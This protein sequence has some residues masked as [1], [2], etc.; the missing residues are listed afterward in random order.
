MAHMKTLTINGETFMVVS[1]TPVASVKVLA[2]AWVGNSSPYS[3]VVAL[4]GV[5]TSTKVDIQLSD[6]QLAVFHNKDLAFTT[7]NKN[8][9][10]TVYAIGQKPVNDYTFQVSTTEVVNHVGGE[11]FGNTVGTP[12]LPPDLAQ[13]DPK[14]SDYIK[15]KE[16]Y[17]KADE[18]DAKID[19]AMAKAY[20]E[21]KYEGKSA[22]QYAVDGGYTGTEAEFTEMLMANA[23]GADRLLI[24]SE[25][26]TV[27]T[28]ETTVFKTSCRLVPDMWYTVSWKGKEYVCHCRGG[29]S[30]AWVGASTGVLGD[31]TFPF[32]IYDD[33]AAGEYI[34]STNETGPLSITAGREPVYEISEEYVTA[35]DCESGKNNF[36][37]TL[38]KGTAVFA[39]NQESQIGIQNM[40][41]SQLTVG[42]TYRVFWI[43]KYY[44]CVLKTKVVAG[45]GTWFWL[46]DRDDGTGEPFYL[47]EWY[48]I[49][50]ADLG[51]IC[52]VGRND[53]Y[54]P[55]ET[56]EF[57]ISHLE[58]VTIIPQADMNQN[59]PS[60]LDYVKGRTHWVEREVVYPITQMNHFASTMFDRVGVECLEFQ[61]GEK[62]IVI[63]NGVEYIGVPYEKGGSIVLANEGANVD[64]QENM[65]F[66]ISYNADTANMAIM[67]YLG[68]EYSMSLGIFK[69][70][71][72][73]HPLDKMF[74]P[75]DDINAMI[76]EKTEGTF[77]KSVNGNAPDENG[78]VNVTVPTLLKIRTVQLSSSNCTVSGNTLQF[79]SNIRSQVSN[80][81]YQLGTTTAMLWV[82]ITTS[83][84]SLTIQGPGNY[85][86]RSGTGV[87]GL[88][89]PSG[90]THIPIIISNSN[91]QCGSD[92]TLAN[93]ISSGQYV[94]IT[95]YQMN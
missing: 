51:Y 17:V 43:D 94:N 60:Q 69:Y 24:F 50:D 86:N 76:D 19:D 88:Q 14:M 44:D 48:H 33:Y 10:V 77:V 11:I 61:M 89:M 30:A 78:N 27:V 31:N 29:K 67:N 92:A 68:I 84:L 70:E 32:F 28:P 52:A 82:S 23:S 3:Q 20:A 25:E 26:I 65:L 46:G 62:Y 49:L 79:G 22:Y 57:T 90:S 81:F 9:V 63:I 64:T 91:L 12:M 71:G 72:L 85:I 45:D 95:V 93:A 15:G 73:V 7:S 6:E 13:T 83:D 55:K 35:F 34:I 54:L 36:Y 80:L 16:L 39:E 41:L 58:S 47:Y 53:S 87:L 18:I 37:R 21:G 8:G 38:Y 56:V 5:T 75:M 2:S 4:E 66:I 74:L 42:E 1:P 40:N 59:D